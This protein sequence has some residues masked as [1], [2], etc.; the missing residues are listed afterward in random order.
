MCEALLFG[1]TVIF[2]FQYVRSV[3]LHLIL[4]FL[5]F[6]IHLLHLVRF[7][8]CTPIQ[9]VRDARARTPA[10]LAASRCASLYPH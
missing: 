3:V 1:L 2:L 4:L 5:S 7:L 8:V 10:E 6:C 9:L